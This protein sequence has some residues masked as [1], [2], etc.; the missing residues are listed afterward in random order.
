MLYYVFIGLS[1]NPGN[2]LGA[3]YRVL[4]SVTL[5]HG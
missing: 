4:G 1:N 2:T 3:Y 5:P